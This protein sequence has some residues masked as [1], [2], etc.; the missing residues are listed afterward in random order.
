MAA[1]CEAWTKLRK[2]C[3]QLYGKLGEDCL[4][5]EL[6]EKRCLA[7]KHCAPQARAYY[8]SVSGTRSKGLCASWAEAF[9]FAGELMDETVKDHHSK[10]RELVNSQPPVKAECRRITMDL[11]KCLTKTTF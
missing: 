10:A 2:D 8:G 7:F 11:A 9:T 3:H 1:S 6:E 5:Q 4:V